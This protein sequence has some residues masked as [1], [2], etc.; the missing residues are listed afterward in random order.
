[1]A[2]VT[3]L[4]SRTLR[5]V[6]ALE[7]GQTADPDD[8]L[9][10]LDYFNDLLEQWT[11]EDLMLYAVEL[12]TV[13]IVNGTISYTIGPTGDIVVLRPIE[14]L[15]A[16]ARDSAGLDTLV[17]VIDYQNYESI[18]QKTNANTTIPNVVAYN[19]TQPNGTLLVYP[20]PSSSYTLYLG[21][22]KQL[23]TLT[24][25]DLGTE[26]SFPIGYRKCVID[27]LAPLVCLEFGRKELLEELKQD[28][29]DSKLI[30]KRKNKKNTTMTLDRSFL[31]GEGKAY[32]PY[33]DQN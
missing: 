23:I 4:L 14:V 30:I 11:L 26:F 25:A 10:C 21:V 29:R 17:S 7:S 2:T 1:M 32:N 8:I 33:S 12:I 22:N 16:K 6:G 27:C 9:D 3:E 5:K 20:S 28:A 18:R 31:T 13:P 15:F 24:A 19:P